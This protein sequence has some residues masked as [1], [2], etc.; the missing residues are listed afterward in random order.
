M[1]F[2]PLRCLQ[3]LRAGLQQSAS[4]EGGRQDSIPE[5]LSRFSGLQGGAAAVSLLEALRTMQL[6]LS[7]GQVLKRDRGASKSFL[8]RHL[9]QFMEAGAAEDLDLGLLCPGLVGSEVRAV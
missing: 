3:S 6:L 1:G 9:S 8:A 7:C 2:F 5:A 4:C